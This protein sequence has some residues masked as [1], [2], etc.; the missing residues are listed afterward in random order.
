MINDPKYKTELCKSW[1]ESEFCAYGNKCRFAHGR[2][3]LFDKVINCKKYKQKEC[4]SFFRNKYCGY[5]S[6]CHFRHEERKL[7]EIERSYHT[8]IIQSIELFPIKEIENADFEKISNLF[9]IKHEFNK[10]R[11]SCRLPVFSNLNKNSDN[12]NKHLHSF[13]NINFL[14][15]NQYFKTLEGI[16]NEPNFTLNYINSGLF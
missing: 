5:G 3:E 16:S 9:E 13:S 12:S 1:T 7:Q 14:R 11:V 4:M 6:R 8:Y 15:T 10:F 2:Q